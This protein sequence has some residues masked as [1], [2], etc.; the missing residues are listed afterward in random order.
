MSYADFLV[1]KARTVGQLGH[2]VGLD[3]IHPSLHEWQK[4]AVRWA[5][6]TGRCALWED[7]GL[8]KT[9]QQLEW[10]RLSGKTNLIVT[11]LAVSAQTVREAAIIGIDA[12]YVRSSDQVTGPGIWVT[13]Y[14]MVDR[15]DPEIFDSVVL[16]ESS[17]LKAHD[18]KTR[19]K[20][21]QHFAGVPRRL[22]ATATPAPNDPEE[23]TNQAEFLGVCSRVDM[24]ATYFIH[25][26]E[27]WRL[28]RH[29]IEPMY[30]WMAGWALA[31]RRP[32]DLGYPDDG[33]ILPGLDILAETVSV[34]LEVEG[35]LFA[36]D[37]GGVGG[38]ARVRQETLQARCE[39][40]AQLVAA[41]P[42]RPWILWCGLNSEAQLLEKL[43]PGSVNVYGSMKPEEKAELL[44]S[45]ADGEYPVLVSKSKIA[46]FGMNF[47][48]CADMAFVG[49]NDSWEQYHQCIGRCHRFG[50]TRRVKAHIVLSELESQI[51]VNVARKERE[52]VTRT[53]GLVRA[54][55]K[56][57]NSAA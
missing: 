12:S 9:R 31:L 25:D 53:D 24:L 14:E 30:E 43:V 44:L 22:S 16:D 42:D 37:L 49:L 26:D 27:G 45:F 52:A 8:G 41:E 20:L 13:N 28:K 48:H 47:Q 15:F 46:G 36:T 19:T 57:W 51:A 33:Y 50:Q 40:A 2:E 4:E 54:V 34:E 21:I 11:P 23:L 1:R 5:V 32:S 3:E 29:A 7:V 38:R 56:N 6:R 17:I 18:G 35:Q 55:R 39:R 10:A